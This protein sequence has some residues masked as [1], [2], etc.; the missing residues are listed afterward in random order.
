LIEP[1]FLRDDL[2]TNELF[3]IIKEKVI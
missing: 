1:L 2:E 3:K